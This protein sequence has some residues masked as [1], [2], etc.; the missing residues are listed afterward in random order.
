MTPAGNAGPMPANG[1]KCGTSLA[2]LPLLLPLSREFPFGTNSPLFLDLFG[3][4]L[5][6]HHLVGLLYQ[7]LQFIPRDRIEAIEH[8]PF[9]SA[10][11]RRWANT[12]ALDQFRKLLGG[13][14]ETEAWIVQTE[15]DKNLIGDLEAEFV[16]PLKILG[17]P[18]QIQAKLTN[19][20]YIHWLSILN[21]SG[22]R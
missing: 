20:V 1:H 22:P 13:T 15:H 16:A 5:R 10:N 21:R 8:H 9:V 19:R 11:V 3:R 6:R 4:R 18:R 7:L 2:L 17:S 14:L 12:L